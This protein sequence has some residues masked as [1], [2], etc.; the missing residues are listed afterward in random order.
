MFENHN[1]PVA[2]L[3]V[4]LPRLFY[5]IAL[6]IVLV[7][8]GLAI[9]VTGYTYFEP[10][11]LEDALVNSSLI[12]A[13]MGPAKIFTSAGGKMF[14]AIYALFSG[15]VFVSIVGVIFA[16]IIHRF[17]HQFFYPSIQNNL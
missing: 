14:V 13:D 9:G 15:L 5:S 8:I 10:M 12:L 16:P 6:A 3:S 2:P 11:P 1:Q 7:M 17:C 4:F